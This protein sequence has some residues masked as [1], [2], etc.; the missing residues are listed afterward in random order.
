[1]KRILFSILASI[2][3]IISSC[4]DNITT[5]VVT[6]SDGTVSIS[7]NYL[8]LL[9]DSTHFAVWVFGKDSVKLDNFKVANS[10]ASYS[11][12]Y[13]VKLGHMQGAK[14]LAVTIEHDSSTLN[15]SIS[16][17]RRFLAGIFSAN[18]V[19]LS[20]KTDIAFNNDFSTVTGKY[21][22][23]T[24]TDTVNAVKKSGI[25]FVKNVDA[26]PILPA[27]VLP[28]LPA[29]WEYNAWV[30]IDGKLLKTGGFRSA[31]I[32]DNDSTYCGPLSI[33]NYPGEDFLNNAPTGVS[34]PVDLSGKTLFITIQPTDWKLD[35][36]FNLEILKATI[37][38]NA[39]EFVSY[40]LEKNLVLP[41][42]S[43]TVVF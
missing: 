43:G 9:S 13:D 15:D 30:T 38:A 26:P 6:E 23:F 18:K 39:T 1:M 3:I 7:L 33:P 34:F 36:A 21:T 11:K 22:L 42:G 19:N 41:S 5:T 16:R 12:T 10:G 31:S 25:W 27:L 20:V 4:T 24:P 14:Y 40:D 17:G 2:L 32:K 8:P 29:G 28:S 35:R 37:P